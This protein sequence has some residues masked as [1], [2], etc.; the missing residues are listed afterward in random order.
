MIA[1]ELC[2]I[3]EGLESMIENSGDNITVA[4]GQ[5]MDQFI[6]AEYREAANAYFKGV[7]IG[8]TTV[9]S[10]ITINGLF[11]AIVVAEPKGAVPA[12]LSGIV[13]IVPWFA[14]VT[15]LSLMVALPHYFRHLNNCSHRCAELE[16]KFDGR[17]FRR[18]SNIA[19]TKNSFN[20]GIGISMIVGIIAALW[21]Y[22]AIQ[23][24]YPGLSLWSAIRS[25][26]GR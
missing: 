16:E 9:K 21:I 10:Y 14:L 23:V 8:Y 26:F 2:T 1:K 18:L 22:F 17:L 3:S 4:P 12:A 24:S 20:T 15:S 19:S 25:V 5:P 7:D 11:V 6:L 13:R